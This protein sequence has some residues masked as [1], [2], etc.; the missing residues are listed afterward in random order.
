MQIC[1]AFPLYRAV[2]VENIR[3]PHAVLA[4]MIRQGHAARLAYVIGLEQPGQRRGL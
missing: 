1:W 2:V 4:D 3:A